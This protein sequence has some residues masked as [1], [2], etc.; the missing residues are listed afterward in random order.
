MVILKNLRLFLQK[1]I[2]ICSHLGRSVGI[3]TDVEDH[4]LGSFVESHAGLL[5]QKQKKPTVRDRQDVPPNL[6]HVVCGSLVPFLPE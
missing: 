6:S 4:S 1:A 3:V 2:G 5:K